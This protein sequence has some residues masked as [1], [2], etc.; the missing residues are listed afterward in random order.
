MNFNSPK[1]TRCELSVEFRRPTSHSKHVYA[2]GGRWMRMSFPLLPMMSFFCSCS[3][4]RFFRS[5]LSVFL[6]K[7]S[8]FRERMDDC[9]VFLHSKP[10][11]RKND[12]EYISEN[13]LHIVLLVVEGFQEFKISTFN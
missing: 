9:S 2:T 10:A 7:C 12:I 6:K 5:A 1:A 8:E 13:I 11:G 4:K 3:Q